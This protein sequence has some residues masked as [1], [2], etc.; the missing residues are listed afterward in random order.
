[1]GGMIQAS[2]PVGDPDSNWKE[3]KMDM[4]RSI[5]IR[6]PFQFITENAFQSIQQIGRQSFWSMRVRM[7]TRRM[8]RMNR[9]TTAFERENITNLLRSTP[10]YDISCYY[11][12]FFST[13]PAAFA[14]RVLF[15]LKGTLDEVSLPK[16]VK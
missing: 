15:H 3:Q 16:P 5:A 10:G 11:F 14:A 1:M 9:H 7:V 8:L 2:R 13:N 12:I 6:Y 4:M